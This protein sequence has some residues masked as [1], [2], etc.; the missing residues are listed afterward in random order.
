M[1]EVPPEDERYEIAQNRIAAYA[2]NKALAL[3]EA[4]KLEAQP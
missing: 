4:E 2:S 3:Q 1:A